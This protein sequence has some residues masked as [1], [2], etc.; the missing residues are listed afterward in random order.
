MERQC[1]VEIGM[2]NLTGNGFKIALEGELLYAVRDIHPSAQLIRI[3]QLRNRW[4]S[5]PTSYRVRAH[6]CP[7]QRR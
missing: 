5:M 6:L 4:H 7:L 1:K 2:D 3:L